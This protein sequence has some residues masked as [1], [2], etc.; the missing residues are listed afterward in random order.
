MEEGP[1][2]LLRHAAVVVCVAPGPAVA[3]WLPWGAEREGVDTFAARVLTVTAICRQQ[4]HR[5]LTFLADATHA[6]RA[7]LPAPTLISTR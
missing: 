1:R 3:Q 4:Q 7:H 5:M 2:I 6:Y